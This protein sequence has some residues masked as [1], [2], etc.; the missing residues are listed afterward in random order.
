MEVNYHIVIMLFLIGA[1]L[2]I[3]WSKA[4][5]GWDNFYKNDPKAFRTGVFG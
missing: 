2:A 4:K 5:A 1:C 3:N